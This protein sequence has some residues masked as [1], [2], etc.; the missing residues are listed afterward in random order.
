[1]HDLSSKFQ[2]SECNVVIF[3]HVPRYALD[4]PH[5]AVDTLATAGQGGIVFSYDRHNMQIFNGKNCVPDFYALERNTFHENC[6]RFP[7]GN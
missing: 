5:H 1:M 6:Y 2:V 3:M 4:V 7:S